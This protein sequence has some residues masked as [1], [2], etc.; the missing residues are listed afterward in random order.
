M[1]SNLFMLNNIH[2]CI[3]NSGYDVLCKPDYDP[4]KNYTKHAIVTSDVW[5]KLQYE[6]CS[7]VYLV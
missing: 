2:A 4:G 3:N 5:Q 1:C 6:N 7:I